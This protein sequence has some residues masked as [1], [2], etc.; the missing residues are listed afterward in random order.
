LASADPDGLERVGTD[1]GFIEAARGAI[2]EILP[3]YTVPGVDDPILSTILAGLIGVG[4]VFVVMV[5]IGQLL[6]RRQAG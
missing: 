3:D 5:I 6:R 2:Y 4:V 1:H